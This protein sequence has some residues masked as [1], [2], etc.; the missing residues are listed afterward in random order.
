MNYGIATWLTGIAETEFPSG[1][2]VAFNIGLFEGA[3]GFTAYLIGSKEYDS[4]DSDWACS[5]DFVPERKYF[6]LEHSIGKEW[7]LLES[8][9]VNEVKSFLLSPSAAKS[10]FAKAV[11]VTVGFDDGDLVKVGP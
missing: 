10:F 1:G 4:S 3:E 2:V 9:V 11:A 8:E 5:E 7:G 6:K